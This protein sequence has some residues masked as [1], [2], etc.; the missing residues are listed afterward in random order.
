VEKECVC[1]G[2]NQNCRRCAGSGTVSVKI[3]PVQL[4]LDRQLKEQSAMASY[5]E[6][7]VPG[8]FI[9]LRGDKKFRVVRTIKASEGNISYAINELQPV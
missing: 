4:S 1:K 5:V 9:S 3:D 6:G 2:T 7:E 8:E